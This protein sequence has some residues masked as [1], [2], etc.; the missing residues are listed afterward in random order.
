MSP[1]LEFLNSHASVRAFTGQEISAEQERLIV[2][3]AQ[4]SPT[5]SNLQ[6]YSIIGVRDKQTKKQ[7]AILCGNQTHIDG[8]SV[9]LVFCADLH[10]LSLLN[11]DRGYPF[12]GEYTELFLVATV[13]ASL[14][15][16]RALMTAQALDLSGVMVGGVRTNIQEVSDLLKLPELVYPVMGMS[17]GYPA[18]PAKVKPRLPLDAIYHREQYQNEDV[19]DQIREYDRIISEVGYLKGREVEPEKYP[20]FSGAYTWSEHTARRTASTQKS[21]LR[22]HMLSFLQKKGFLLK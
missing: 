8:A 13:D 16:A 3:T 22:P 18:K 19:R 17:L 1:I 20:N 10:R 21:S 11:S 4:R 14:A 9:F 7:L 5:S 15:A 6:A 2:T 12:N